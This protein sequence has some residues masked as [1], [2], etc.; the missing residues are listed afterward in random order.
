[1][2]NLASDQDAYP[3]DD[4][5]TNVLEGSRKRERMGQQQLYY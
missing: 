1:M 3:L 2:M 4:L 5:L